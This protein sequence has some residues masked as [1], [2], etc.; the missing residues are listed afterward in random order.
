MRRL[1]IS[2]D[3]DERQSGFGHQY[4]TAANAYEAIQMVK[5]LYGRRLVSEGANFLTSQVSC[6]PRL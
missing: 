4:A 6:P 3:K 1:F 5:A 2:C